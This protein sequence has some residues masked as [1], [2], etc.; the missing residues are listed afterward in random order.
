MINRY[1]H[2][3]GVLVVL[4]LAFFNTHAVFAC[5]AP[6][7]GT[8]S[9]V[10]LGFDIKEVLTVSIGAPDEGATGDANQFLRNI[11]Q[12]SVDT[13]NA[14]G[15]VATMTTKVSNANLVNNASS[16]AYL[17]TLSTWYTRANFPANYWGYSLEDVIASDNC[18]S[19][20]YNKIAAND[21]TPNTINDASITGPNYAASWSR[22]IAFGAKFDSSK[23]A[24]TYSAVV[25]FTV[26]TGSVDSFSPGN[27]TVG[28]A[29]NP[30]PSYDSS[31]NVTVYTSTTR[32]GSGTSARTT[33]TSDI[34]RGDH[35]SDYVA[36]QGVTT[37]VSTN[38]S[39][40]TPLATGL[41]VTATVA[42][43]TGIIFFI[44]A[45]RRKD[46]DE[47]EEVEIDIN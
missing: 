31:D 25:V 36:P 43:T 37:T 11:Y 1:I 3:I 14:R 29:D 44:V 46:D 13:N 35:R 22:K 33:I 12:V 34:S 5:T 8:C 23:P 41:A 45:K 18:S 42:A 9:D 10:G 21:E 20:G 24:G 40:G 30:N 26:V 47:E 32:S 19:C 38:I 16:S 28:P 27:P 6:S 4:V 17:P 39:E 15:S 2:K 7:D